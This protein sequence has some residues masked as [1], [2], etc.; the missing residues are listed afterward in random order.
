MKIR[1]LD[2][3]LAIA[4]LLCLAFSIYQYSNASTL[5]KDNDRLL[6]EKNELDKQIS[7][8]NTEVSGLKSDY[9][10]LQTELTEASEANT[11]LV[12]TDQKVQQEI[13][14]AN[15]TLKQCQAMLANMRDVL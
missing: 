6:T 4:L 5:K 2:V 7:A 8:L 14:A 3:V 13:A 12:D 10:A 9:S 11:A 15:A 1:K